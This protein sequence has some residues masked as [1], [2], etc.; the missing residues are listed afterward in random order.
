[1]KH[2][3]LRDTWTTS[4][5]NELGRLSKGTD[6]ILFV[7]KS[8]IPISRIKY[9]TYARIVLAY[10]PDKLEKNRTR[11]TVDG[12]RINCLFD[13]GTPTADVPIIKL[14]WNSTLS[15]PGAK[16]FTLD[17][18]NFYLGTPMERPEYMKMP[19]KIMPQK[20]IDKYNLNSMASDGW[21]YI[22]IVKGMYG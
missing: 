20:I 22:K 14:L 1:M 17:I 3:K 5:A 15:T 8:E 13:C 2:P 7:P 11:L 12:D 19:L 4:L 18:S 21:V 16:Y 6:T 10:K 9:V